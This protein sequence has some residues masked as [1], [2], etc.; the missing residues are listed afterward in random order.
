LLSPPSPIGLNRT[1]KLRLASP[2]RQ[3]QVAAAL[4]EAAPQFCMMAAAERA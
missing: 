3:Q 1:E 2:Q 4:V